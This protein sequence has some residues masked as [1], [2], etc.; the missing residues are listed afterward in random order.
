MAIINLYTKSDDDEQYELQVINF[1]G[2]AVAW[3][4]KNIDAGQNFSVYE[5][6]LSKEHEISRDYEKIFTAEEVSIFILPAGG[7]VVAGYVIAAVLVVAALAIKP[8]AMP[9]VNRSQQS[10]N[11]SLSD[12]NNKARPNQRIVDIC[13]QVKSIPDVIAREYSRFVDNIEERIGYYCIGRNDLLVEDIKEGDT[14]IADIETASAGVYG[15]N[16]SPNNSSPDIQIGDLINEN[17]YGVTQS[18]DAIGQTLRASNENL[19]KLD[20]VFSVEDGGF[21]VGIIND[22]NN[23]VDF[24]ENYEAGDTVNLKEIYITV[25]DGFGGDITYQIGAETHIVSVVEAHKITFDTGFDESWGNIGSTP[26]NI[27]SGTDAR[28][29]GITDVLVGPFKMTSFKVNRLLVNVNALNGVYKEN[30]SGRK[31]TTVSY[32]VRYQKLDDGGN[33]VGSEVSLIES[34]TGKDSR[35]K[36][37]TTGIDLGGDT[38]VQWSVERLTP[39]DYDFNGT[40]VDEIKVNSVFGLINIDKDHFG[41]VTTIQTKRTNEFLATATKTPEINCIATELVQKYEGGSFSPSFTPN[42]Q[43]MQSLIRLALDPFVGR[44]EQ[45]ELDLN[46]LVAIQGECE[47]YFES[48][49][50]GEFNYSFDSTSLSAQEV[51]LAIGKA[52]FM[53]LWRE[54]RVLKGW[55]ESPQSIPSMVFTHRSKQPNNETWS[56]KLSSNDSKDSIE[57]VY[58]DDEQHTKE[59][60]YYPV[61][62]SG[63]NPERIEMTGVKG[64]E[65]ATWHMMRLFN[66]RKYQEISVD[67]GATAEGRFVKPNNL[68]SVVKG[69]RVYTYDGYVVA[70]NG[71][72]VTL[73]QNVAFTPNDGHSLIL[74]NRDGTTESITVFETENKNIVKLVEPPA[75]T[76]YTGN[77]ALKTEFSFGNE[78]RLEGQLMLPQE[79]SPSDQSYVKIK[80]INYSSLYY[81]SDKQQPER[82]F[83]SGFDEGFS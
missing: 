24:T 27:D 79:I 64:L 19:L 39:I 51:F 56:R 45:S 59:T 29:E 10:P 66:K 57:F 9:N 11:N 55:F 20:G 28:I 60:L 78:A 76:I 63:T 71:L 31:G 1:D 2:N 67:F 65:Q 46:N 14:L 38:F 6:E 30:S 33:P 81:S 17:V 48:A 69:S 13:G 34:I 68:I 43:A 22:V 50:A 80:A 23:D 37:L 16:K 61:D 5:G 26:V 83:S 47:S 4:L 25:D 49:R 35:Q 42:T 52:A 21:N 73:S 58:T 40:I 18:P 41:N 70:V 32:Y 77:D 3:M 36:G 74:K 44:R 15:A 8:A 82:A 53:T 62:Q 7:L 72:F 12:R 75:Q 54:G